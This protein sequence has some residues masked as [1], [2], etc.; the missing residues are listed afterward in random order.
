[1]FSLYIKIMYQLLLFLFTTSFLRPF[2][3]RREKDRDL[4]QSCDKSPYNDRKIQK[5]QR[6]NTKTP[7]K[8][9]ITQRLRTDLG[10]LV[11]VTTTQLVWLNRFTGSQPS[12]LLQKPCN[13]K[14]T[15]LKNCE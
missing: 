15:H 10:R 1:M 9:S 2:T 11:L 13:Q 5:K 14:D 12:H 6:D 7:P 8:T 3:S 4:T